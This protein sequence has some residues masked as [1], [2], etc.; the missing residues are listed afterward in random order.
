MTRVLCGAVLLLGLALGQTSAEERI[1]PEGIDGSLLLCGSQPPD[2]AFE[3]FVDL[4]GKD[5]ANLV[6]L[7]VA[8][9]SADP[10]TSPVTRLEAASKTGLVRV[11]FAPGKAT[12]E[13]VQGSIRKATGVWI[14]GGPLDKLHAGLKW[15]EID[16][17]LLGVLQRGG[18]V[19]G[20]GNSSAVL[21]QEFKGPDNEKNGPGFNLLSGVLADSF[22]AAADKPRLPTAL[23]RASGLVGLSLAENAALLVKARDLHV[24]GEGNATFFLAKSPTQEVRTIVLKPRA[25]HD[26]TLL[27]R[28]AVARAGKPFP[29]AEVP[30]SEVASGSLVIV[31]GGGM[32]PEVVKKFI[33]LAG[34]PDALI[35]VLPTAQPDPVP[36]T[37]GGFLQRAGAK[38]VI[39]L[40]SRHL[41]DVD[42]PKNLALLKKA[43]GIWFGGGRQWRFVD[44]YEK[45]QALD[46]F[47]DVLK[48]GG[49]I[50]G[51]SAGATIQGDYLCRGSPFDNTEMMCEGYER[52][53]GFLPGAAI[54][55]HFGR[56]NRF[57][58]MT[59]L[60]KTHPQLLGIGIDETTAL[61][62]RGTVGE[63]MGQ[64]QVY[65]YDRKKPIQKDSPDYDAVKSGGRYDVKERKILANTKE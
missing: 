24:L 60:M 12:K 31:G 42:D 40:P 37:E 2:L 3:R 50:G 33:A 64:G 63:V 41:K 28:C 13:S 16:K 30:G 22:P 23:E 14:D 5:K 18:V 54:D 20:Q 29:P 27:R 39:T 35:I 44:A 19:A 57:G 53:L 6:L 4:A 61:I 65:F 52:G 62:V 36:F 8:G 59:A 38:K 10:K 55:Q 48:R 34:G 9:I 32:P 56:R 45:T 25:T 26:L 46:L 17:E 11:V 7:E 58:D 51:S 47:H 15:A 43:G 49:V 21:C 1:R